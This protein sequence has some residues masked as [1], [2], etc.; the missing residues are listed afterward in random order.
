MLCENR[1]YKMHEGANGKHAMSLVMIQSK[2]VANTKQ[3]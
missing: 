1:L 3:R 2:C